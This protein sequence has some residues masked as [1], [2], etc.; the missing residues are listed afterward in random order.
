MG[1]NDSFQNAEI[2]ILGGFDI[3]SYTVEDLKQG[4]ET[5][6]SMGAPR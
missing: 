1:W 4:I 3:N 6:L 2:D 5:D